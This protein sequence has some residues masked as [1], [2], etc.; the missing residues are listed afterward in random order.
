LKNFS[1]KLLFQACK[2]NKTIGQE[3]IS[4]ILSAE[5]KYVYSEYQLFIQQKKFRENQ[6]RRNVYI[7]KKTKIKSLKINI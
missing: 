5:F 3:V 6:N 4:L 7:E 2:K 1:E